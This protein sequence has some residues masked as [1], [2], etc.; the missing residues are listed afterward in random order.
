VRDN[1]LEKIARHRLMYVSIPQS[2][3]A[4]RYV[5]VCGRVMVCKLTLAYAKRFFWI[6]IICINYNPCSIPKRKCIEISID[7]DFSFEG[8]QNTKDIS[9]HVYFK[10]YNIVALVASFTNTILDNSFFT[11]GD[12]ALLSDR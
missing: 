5:N 4:P 7:K 11:K 6:C 12:F 9:K 2:Q 1:T 3:K 10:V 8:K